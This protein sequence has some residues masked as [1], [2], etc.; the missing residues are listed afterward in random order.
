MFYIEDL[1]EELIGPRKFFD[2]ITIFMGLEFIYSVICARI[3]ITYVFPFPV[4]SWR[5]DVTISSVVMRTNKPSTLWN[6][7]YLLFLSSL[8]RFRLITF[9]L[10]ILYVNTLVLSS[11]RT[12]RSN[13]SMS[14]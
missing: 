2:L 10:S 8:V 3:D 4:L 6:M 5:I 1:W 13:S 14:M 9:S 11:F 12:R 7:K